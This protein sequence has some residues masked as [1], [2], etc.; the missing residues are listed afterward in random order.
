M[1]T[2]ALPLLLTVTLAT[3]VLA[4]CGANTMRPG[5][6]KVSAAKQTLRAKSADDPLPFHETAAKAIEMINTSPAWRN[7]RLVSIEGH[8]FDQA[9]K[10]VPLLGSYWVFKFWA[11]PVDED[12]KVAQDVV[13]ADVIVHVE[14]NAELVDGSE[15]K[16][17]KL[18]RVLDP[19][20]LAPPTK[21]VPFAI[22]LGLKVNP[23][24]PAFNYYDVT[25]NSF[26]ANP[27][28]ARTDVADVTSYY[29]RDTFDGLHIPARPELL[30]ADP[31]PA[32][33]PAVPPVP[34]VSRMS[35]QELAVETAERSRQHR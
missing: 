9:G 22:A 6:A 4:G 8:G 16:E 7:A 29:Q 27:S 30:P 5:M 28:A 11:N 20:K 2:R 18:E 35:G 26:Y 14:G 32:P 23:A 15:E 3:L 31:V 19:A 33:G 25:Y 10:M 1:K 34:G 17:V 21:I 24:G 12:G 13:R